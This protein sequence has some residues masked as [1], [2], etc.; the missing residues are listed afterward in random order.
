MLYVRRTQTKQLNTEKVTLL[1]SVRCVIYNTK[2]N[3]PDNNEGT[4]NLSIYE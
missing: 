3:S 4:I 2:W 1:I